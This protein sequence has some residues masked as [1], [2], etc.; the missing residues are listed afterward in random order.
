MPKDFKTI[1]KRLSSP[2][3]I[4]S[5]QR[6]SHGE[7]AHS[8]VSLF[9]S[10]VPHLEFTSP[11]N[12]A[13]KSANQQPLA[14]AVNFLKDKVLWNDV[15]NIK[16]L[17]ELAGDLGPFVYVPFSQNKT[18]NTV[19]GLAMK[20]DLL[21]DM[22]S[23]SRI[24]A[25]SKNP[26]ARK[27]TLKQSQSIC[28]QLLSG[29]KRLHARNLVHR[30]MA[31]R[32]F[33]IKQHHDEYHV[34]IGDLFD[35]LTGVNHEGRFI[36][37]RDIKR[38]SDGTVTYSVTHPH[39]FV[40]TG[41]L[42]TTEIPTS[43]NEPEL[44]IRSWELII[45][46][47]SMLQ[48]YHISR[49]QYDAPEVQLL[50]EYN[51]RE[52][53]LKNGKI[54][55]YYNLDFKAVDIYALG[56]AFKELMKETDFRNDPGAE[57][58]MQD[59]CDRLT[60][61]DPKKR[62]TVQQ[63]MAHPFFVED[64]QQRNRLFQN[65]QN[66]PVE[67]DMALRQIR[68]ETIPTPVKRVVPASS[69]SASLALETKEEALPEWLQQSQSLTNKYFN[70]L[71]A[72]FQPA[73]INGYRLP[74]LEDEEDNF[75]AMDAAIQSIYQKVQ[76]LDLLIN[77]FRKL[78]NIVG[79]DAERSLH[80][81]REGIFDHVRIIKD[82]IKKTHKNP[83]LAE[84][85]A[86]LRELESCV[87]T[88]FAEFREIDAAQR[89]QRLTAT[90]L[91]EVV[92][93]ACIAYE[94]KN[95]WNAAT[96]KITQKRWE[97]SGCK[98]ACHDQEGRDRARRFRAEIC[99]LIP[100]PSNFDQSYLAYTIFMKI[101]DHLENSNSGFAPCSFKR[102]LLNELNNVFGASLEKIKHTLDPR[103]KIVILNE[104]EIAADL[105]LIPRAVRRQWH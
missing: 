24:R 64:S 46:K 84:F 28:A 4:R 26:Q 97:W 85:H 52:I 35:S 20:T 89:L 27:Y 77:Q 33:L 76:D 44:S 75:V 29:L 57:A 102:L 93:Q 3:R 69:S 30:D 2:D 54:E 25:I 59:L 105:G 98:L 17:L 65:K 94:E 32:N 49:Q 12:S 95:G 43:M 14:L 82:E 37:H 21:H 58:I 96:P 45:K 83:H 11:F 99:N 56:V 13:N 5:K 16:K 78:K 104:D 31:E 100:A 61:P 60:E 48:L 74:V 72:Q 22:A 92:D 90:R 67:F 88:N 19:T 1:L 73:R 18:Q 71:E 38:Q 70:A 34:Q 36:C 51:K 10:V 86:D 91:T 15:E 81:L 103:T 39:G 41:V 47:H 87:D 9:N 8:V 80:H 68:P 63:A 101:L 55:D 40:F 23:Q 42:T 66:S 7:G 6:Y 50:L 79:R 62:L 53:N